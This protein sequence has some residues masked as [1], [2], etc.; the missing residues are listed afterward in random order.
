MVL[1]ATMAG[2]AMKHASPPTFESLRR[3]A[4]RTGKLTIL[5]PAAAMEGRTKPERGDHI[6]MPGGAE[7][8]YV[9]RK[10]GVDWV[11]YELSSFPALVEAFDGGAH[12]QNYTQVYGENAGEK[13]L[14]LLL[15]VGAVSA[16]IY[17]VYKAG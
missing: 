3:R 16:G 11:A 7:G 1:C 17:T 12:G 9:G 15:L 13:T 8:W 14:G 4:G 6:I 10:N 5:S 2:G